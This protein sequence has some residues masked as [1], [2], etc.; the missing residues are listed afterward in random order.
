[1]SP[2]SRLLPLLT[3]AS[4][5]NM[6][7]TQSGFLENY[8]QLAEVEERPKQRRFINED[9]DWDSFDGVHLE[10]TVYRP[11]AG[12]EDIISAGTAEYL[13][14][15]LDEEWH[16]VFGLYFDAAE[17]A[18]PLRIRA[19]I[20]DVDRSN[21]WTNLLTMIVLLPA[22]TG[23]S[24][25]ELEILDGTSGERLA[26]LVKAD[27]GKRRRTKGSSGTSC[28]PC[29]RS[30]TRSRGSTTS[31]S[32]WTTSSSTAALSAA[33]RSDAGCRELARLGACRWCDGQQS[34]PVEFDIPEGGD[35]KLMFVFVRAEDDG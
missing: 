27:E 17:P 15:Y 1:M 24:T 33:S 13:T 35:E 14:T 7:P 9:I 2:F 20:T 18:R 8:D 26:A 6:Q 30:A 32:G 34:A 22:D 12:R 28:R 23:G 25:V 11:A 10:P 4:C 29:D 31:S 21:F 19:A 16:E 5:A 3:L